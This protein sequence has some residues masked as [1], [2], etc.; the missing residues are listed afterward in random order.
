MLLLL[1]L[2]LL[3]LRLLM[4]LEMVLRLRLLIDKVSAQIADNLIGRGKRSR[5]QSTRS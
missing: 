4:V 2:L 5:Q 3:L 1:L